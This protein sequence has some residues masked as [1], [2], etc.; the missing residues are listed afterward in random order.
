MDNELTV[1][2]MPY[3]LTA[4]DLDAVKRDHFCDFDDKDELY[5]RLG[6]LVFAYD[7]I[8]AERLKTLNAA[9]PAPT[10]ERK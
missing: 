9:P 6:W 7:T 3:R 5:K 1:P 2:V 10:F 4:D 8:V